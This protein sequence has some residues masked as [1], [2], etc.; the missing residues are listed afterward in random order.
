MSGATVESLW[1]LQPMLRILTEDER[2][3][4]IDRDD[5]THLTKAEIVT[6]PVT[7]TTKKSMLSPCRRSG[8]QELLWFERER[9]S[10]EL[11]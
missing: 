11:L 5:T 3:V 8:G 1:R 10:P 4:Q 7:K 2:S 9:A 6:A